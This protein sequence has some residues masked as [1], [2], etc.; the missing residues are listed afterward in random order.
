MSGAS[1]GDGAAREPWPDL[2]SAVV[3]Q[4]TQGVAV[5]DLGGH[6]QFV[7]RAFARMHGYE[8]EELIGRH[9][10]V[11]HC[12]EQIPAVEAANRALREQGEFAGE[13]W[14][15]RRDGTAFPARMYNCLLR[16]SDGRPVGMIGTAVD[17]SELKRVEDALRE[18]EERFRKIFDESPLGMGLVGLD[19]RF[20]RVN[21][22]LC[23][24]LGY[25]AAELTSLSLADVIP[26]DDWAAIQAPDAQ[27]FDGHLGG[28]QR[29]LRH[30]R[31]DGTVLWVHLTVTL[32]RGEDGRPHYGLGMVEDITDRRHADEERRLHHERLEELVTQR[33][34]ELARVAA[35][36]ERELAERC[37]T[38]EA[39]RDSDERFR[40]LAENI[41]E[42]FWLSDIRGEKALYVSPA[43]ESIWGRPVAEAYANPMIW[44]EGIHPDD[45]ER[46]LADQARQ[47]E[48]MATTHEYRLRRPDGSLCW[49]RSRA[50]PIRNADGRVYRVAGIAEDVTERKQ[51]EALLDLQ[52]D[53]GLALGNA[54]DLPAALNALLE[55]GLRIG[56]FDCGGAY[57]VDATDQSLRL[58]R[59]AGLSPAYTQRVARLEPDSAVGRVLLSAAPTYGVAAELFPELA[60]PL[61]AEAVPVVAIV[62]VLH[63]GRPVAALAL[64]TDHADVLPV[65]VR[66]TL[67]AIASQAAGTI[68]R[69]AAQ[70]ALR[71]SEERFRAVVTAS[72]DAMIAVDRRGHITLFNP[73]A[74]QLFGRRGREM[75][76]QPLD[77][78]LPPAYRRRHQ[79]YV[80]S[81][82]TQG[83]TRGVIG[84]PT[85]LP[86]LR[87]DGTIVPVELSLSAGHQGDEPFVLAV[88]R[89]ISERRRAEAA[90]HEAQER[91]ELALKGAEL[92]LWD[93]NVATGYVVYN[94][95]WAEMLG[96]RLDELEPRYSTWERLV[97]PDDKPRVLKE[98]NDHL[99]GRSAFYA[100][101]HRLRCKDGEYKWILA[102]GQVVQR[103][104]DGRPLRA[105]GTHLD[106]TARK[107]T[108]E[109]TRQHREQLAHVARVS[110][111]GEMASG[112]AHEL[113]QP[114]SA[115]LY[116]AKGCAARLEAGEWSAAQTVE[117]LQKVAAQAERAGEFV[118]R[119]KA[120]VRRAQATPQPC[121]IN[122]IVRAAIG[123]TAAETRGHEVALRLDLTPDLP[124][125]CVDRIQIEQVI[126]N[127]VRNGIEALDH[128]PAGER[129][130]VVRTLAGQDHTVCVTVRDHGSGVAEAAAPHLFEPFFSTKPGGTGLGLSISRTIIEEMHD[131]ELWFE[132][133]V[134]RG[135]VFGFSLPVHEGQGHG[136]GADGFRR[137]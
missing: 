54:T 41:R 108:E 101:E 59:S 70:E 71:A 96:Y 107:Q 58:V 77:E 6:L 62:P 52:R 80:H 29:E 76:G 24:L 68:A 82:F 9:L 116:Y 13:V 121:D 67:E 7:N 56:I 23:R 73:A 100:T 131:G 132:P 27:M 64:G 69:L 10:S 63:E 75:L 79:E 4:S 33:T 72:K 85:E 122:D 14:H 57:V 43:F 65:S 50:F 118:R 133:G 137:G 47:R 45:V 104:A 93:W 95:R 126:L 32:I 19:R 90:L 91:L 44:M 123:F 94:E 110:T 35:D 74:E 87:R 53:L 26:P 128:T 97:H 109:L 31:K 78:L 2:L 129:E 8:P 102:S 89:D 22:A 15:T 17:V 36:L 60:D 34:A 16:D 112:L 5:T 134:P 98:L 124:P 111:I 84:R 1:A 66:T 39:L 99:A 25:S 81:F 135:A 42:M 86:A 30:H 83:G 3:E 20:V 103:D 105:T 114:L 115:I 127:L 125:V 61:R 37:R 55:A 48:G 130:V 106:I 18:S 117:T 136:N 21:Q 28:F 38:E 92:G 120:F 12:P 113:A 119:L 11:F 51:T 88:L 46:V 40:Q 49:I